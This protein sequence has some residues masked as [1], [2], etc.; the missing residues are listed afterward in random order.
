MPKIFPVSQS[1]CGQCKGACC[2]QMPGIC[3][4]KDIIKMFPAKTLKESVI[5]ALRTHDFSIDYW[6]GEKSVY[7]IRPSTLTGRGKI[8]DASW[9]GQCVF[10][11]SD[12]CGLGENRPLEC[13]MLRPS[14]TASGSCDYKLRFPAKKVFGRLWRRYI[15]LGNFEYVS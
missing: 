1:R 13:K 12:G 6:E 14:K 5:K 4:P 7:Y 2:K 9:G 15:D 8:W 3:E 11:K 10:L